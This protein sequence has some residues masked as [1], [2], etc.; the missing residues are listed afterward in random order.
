MYH[1]CQ[2]IIIQLSITTTHF[3]SRVVDLVVGELIEVGWLNRQVD[4][5]PPAPSQ[6]SQARQHRQVVDSHT[7]LAHTRSYFII[8]NVDGID[9]VCTNQ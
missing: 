4:G 6:R 5:R 2:H 9:I 7:V 8:L 1:I 3:D